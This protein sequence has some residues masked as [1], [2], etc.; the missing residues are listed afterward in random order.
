MHARQLD[1]LHRRGD[2]VHPRE[3]L[4]AGR[5]D[6]SRGLHR[7]GHAR[8]QRLNRLAGRGRLNHAGID[9]LAR[10]FGGEHRAGHGFLNVVQDSPHLRG[11]LSRLLRQRADFLRHDGEAPAFV[12]RF[13]RLD[14]G[15]DGED[16]R[17]RRQILHGGNDYADQLALLTQIHDAPG[18]HAHLLAD[19]FHPLDRLAHC[20][21]PGARRLGRLL[22]LLGD[23]L[24]LLARYL[25]GVFHLL[26]R[27]RRLTHLG[28]CF[29][30]GRGELRGGPDD[31]VGKRRE[32]FCREQ[33][34]TILI[35]DVRRPL[36]HAHLEFIARFSQRLLRD[37]ALG[38][39]AVDRPGAPPD[40][41]AE[42]RDAHARQHREA[43]FAF[44]IPGMF[45][46]DPQ[47]AQRHHHRRSRGQEPARHAP[48]DGIAHEHRHHPAI[49]PGEKDA[50]RQQRKAERRMGSH[51]RVPCERGD[52]FRAIRVADQG[53]HRY[54]TRRQYQRLRGSAAPRR[55]AIQQ[56]QSPADE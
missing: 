15:V 37:P 55:L 4:L 44:V 56:Q 18:D 3:L 50:A 46:R 21:C 32:A 49:R 11:R 10:L 40:Q 25:R 41:H 51:L 12:A 29:D 34:L 5:G 13:R 43:E 52:V 39:G 48:A 20:A 42:D 7:L 8:A 31:F 16:L 22:R 17:L 23:H 1:A 26:D 54:E 33:H 27:R 14:R 9:R 45:P 24:R 2:L 36:L 35:R 30:R 47:P 53:Q 6:L 38:I 19:V 28:G